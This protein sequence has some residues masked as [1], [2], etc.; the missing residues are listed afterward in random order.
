MSR[1]SWRNMAKVSVGCAVVI[2]TL[3]LLVCWAIYYGPDKHELTK[4]AH[5]E[6][7]LKFREVGLD[8]VPEHAKYAGG[9]WID[10]IY[11]HWT[12][13]VDVPTMHRWLSRS[14]SL[15]TAEVRTK[16][17]KKA[18]IFYVPAAH[19]ACLVIVF[20]AIAPRWNPQLPDGEA[21]V[22]V[23]TIDIGAKKTHSVGRTRA[24]KDALEDLAHRL[25]SNSLWAED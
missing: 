7:S 10:G 19:R 24:V 23:D 9:A 12:F 17:G 16:P 1:L 6:W 3:L 11:G 13:R 21:M 15:R 14:Q 4:H 22:E 18:Y 2:G 8:E 20:Y 5:T 25:D